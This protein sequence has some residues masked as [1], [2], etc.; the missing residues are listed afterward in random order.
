MH[1]AGRD[2]WRDNL[3][4]HSFSRSILLS[5]P[6]GSELDILVVQRLE[7]QPVDSFQVCFHT[8][9]FAELLMTVVYNVVRLIIFYQAIFV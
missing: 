3:L 2:Y 1:S 8:N 9:Y 7:G 6:G 5:Y 4:P